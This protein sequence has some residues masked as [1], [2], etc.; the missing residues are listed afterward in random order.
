M[1]RNTETARAPHR[2]LVV[3][4]IAVLVALGLPQRG[5]AHDLKVMV[6][7]EGDPIKLE[8][9]F[10]DDTPAEMGRVT[11][12]RENGEEIAAGTT[13]ERGQW[14]FPKPGPGIYRIVVECIG[15]RD[16]L[17]LTIPGAEST[18]APIAVGDFRLSQKL[19]LGIG[20]AMILGGSLAFVLLRLRK[21]K[22]DAVP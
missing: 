2:F 21:G 4:V 3:A 5:S 19:G 22:T 15:H 7:L 17:K 14:S 10:D 12:S 9:W 18:D 1:K 11:V 6:N 13:N 8:A 20:L 16:V